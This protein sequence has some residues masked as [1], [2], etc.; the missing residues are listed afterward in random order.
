[1][2]KVMIADDEERICQLIRALIDWKAMGLELAGFAHNGLEAEELTEK[3]QPDILITDIRMPGI[4]GMELIQRLKKK[5][6]G[7]EIIVIS[8]YAHFEYA[9]QAI[10]YGVGD[11]L[12][13]PISKAELTETLEK[14][15]QRIC[16]R[17]EDEQDKKELRIKAEKDTYRMRHR[18]L[19]DLLERPDVPLSMQAL[20]ESYYLQVR[21]G[22][23]QAFWLKMDCAQ[24]S[25]SDSS[26]LALMEKAQNV[27]ERG[28][29]AKCFEMISVIKDY[30]CVG[31]MNYAR[32]RQEEIR[33]IL[34]GC[35][36]QM[37]LQRELFD[38]V[39]FS[40]SAGG[41][42]EKPELLQESMR[43]ASVLIQDRIVKGTGR[44]LEQRGAPCAAQE[45][46]AL[47]RYLREVAGAVEL[48]STDQADIAVK[49]LLDEVRCVKDMRGR[50]IFEL[51]D[52]AADIFS[53]CTQM[54]ER[55][56]QLEEFKRRC[57]QC[58]STEELFRCQDEYLEKC[59]AQRENDA[60]RP[61]RKAKQYIQNHYS[62][63]ITLEQVSDIVGLSPS[64]FSA[65][66]KKTEGEGFAKYLINIRMEQARILL[67]E[68]NISVVDICRRVGYNDL[69]HFTHTFEK[70]VGVKPGTYRKLYG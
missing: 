20:Q 47:E 26:V 51:V 35:L 60:V 4:S 15:K 28:L 33:K 22:I 5:N 21:P 55:I 45:N 12:L 44:L 8:G 64:Y 6:S 25:L 52:S 62:E 23:F 57:E 49:H 41:A 1:M 3:L 32:E 43:E 14:M 30:S 2:I 53:A 7:L 31:I 59:R 34:K 18:F 11:Y 13:K 68:S 66:F 29:K 58:S 70:T 37:E 27:L 9:Q 42:F 65:L 67:R 16:S 38:P 50:E 40:M 69:K 61:V 19:Q 54:P 56:K 39:S 17:R 48:L 63:P 24:D 10:K 36:S 46:K